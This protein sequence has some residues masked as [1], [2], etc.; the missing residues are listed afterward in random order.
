MAR[1]FWARETELAELE[2]ERRER[3]EAARENQDAD[4][5]ARVFSMRQNLADFVRGGWHVMEPDTPLVWNWHLDYICA[6]L[7]AVTAGL[8]RR[9]IINVPPGHMKS[10]ITSVFWPA[11]MWLQ[12]P[13]TRVLCASYALSLA[14]RDAS[15]TK[16]LVLSEWYQ[17]TFGPDWRI[18]HDSKAKQDYQNS[19]RGSRKSVS[20][21]S[22]TTGFRGKGVIIDDPLSIM[23]GYSEKKKHEA[24]T[25][26]F[27]AAQ[28]RLADPRTG[29]IVMIMQRVAEDDPTGAALLK[30]V[31]KWEHLCLMS[32]FEPERA[33]RTLLADLPLD[34]PLYAK[35][36]HFGTEPRRDAGELLFPGFFTA[37]VIEG[38]KES[39]GPVAYAG[40]HQQRPAP[41]SGHIFKGEH[42][43]EVISIE[44]G[45]PH[46]RLWSQGRLFGEGAIRVREAYMS[47]DTALKD[48][49]TSDYSAGCLVMLCDDGY[50]Y[51]LPLEFKRMEVPDVEKRVVME[52][53][54]WK[55]ILGT[56]LKGVRVEEGAGTALIQ[57]I[58]RM[59]VSR[60]EFEK[61]PFPNWDQSD[62]D[63]V[64]AT[65]PIVV[66]PFHTSQKKIEKAYEVLPFVAGRNVRLLDSP[67]SAAWLGNL[68]TFPFA[69]H[70]DPVDASVNGIGV[71]AGIVKGLTVMPAET[72]ESVLAPDA[73]SVD[74]SVY[75]DVV[76][77]QN[78]AEM[79]E[80]ALS[81]ALAGAGLGDIFGAVTG[82]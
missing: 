58:R 66:F 82:K 2:I 79:V 37:H 59:M 65:P 35:F 61:S 17:E 50:V 32:E 23:D 42:F 70:D 49:T 72:L 44:A 71:F 78:E 11:W 67:L 60:R 38:Q 39:M 12:S 64:R 6:H 16:D 13:G 10:L 19:Q 56:A 25:W 18:R 34:H 74:V 73:S 15:K 3:K 45:E 27:E 62:W 43:L 48:K 75:E 51:L 29:W 22:G 52:W 46:L 47:W 41:A 28:N 33:F 20:V 36:A 7:E 69:S 40:Q 1:D 4:E 76:T 68:T 80:R 53:V 9:L 57:Y 21:G 55:Q 24:R 14:I 8:I 77:V 26:L 63:A 81:D 5:V 31:D 30:L 54:K